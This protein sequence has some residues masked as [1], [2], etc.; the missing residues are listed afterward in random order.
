MKDP[1]RWE[2]EDKLCFGD[3]PFFKVNRK[4]VRF[5]KVPVDVKRKYPRCKQKTVTA[6]CRPM[7]EARYERGHSLPPLNV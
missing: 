7:Q 1:S 6:V 4:G 5:E 3:C 2:T